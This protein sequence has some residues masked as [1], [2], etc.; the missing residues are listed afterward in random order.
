MVVGVSIAA[1][2]T[3]ADVQVTRAAGGTVGPHGETLHTH[4]AHDGIALLSPYPRTHFMDHPD[5]D[6]VCCILPFPF[7]KYV[8]PVPLIALH[9]DGT[10]DAAGLVQ[11]LH[12]SAADGKRPLNESNIVH[13]VQPITTAEITC[14]DDDEEYEEDD[15]DSCASHEDDDASLTESEDE[16]V[17]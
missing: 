12:A 9:E 10:L 11:R 14:D 8:Y 7:S 2:G 16:C 6:N 5:A 17:D 15:Y 1:D 3:C 13:N 4:F